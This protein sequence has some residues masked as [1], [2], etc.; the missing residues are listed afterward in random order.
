MLDPVASLAFVAAHT[1]RV[2]LATGI[3]ILP[4]R[5]PLVLAKSLASLDVLSGGRVVFGLGAGYLHQE[6]AALGEP[7]EDRG[8]RTVRHR[9]EIRLPGPN[10]GPSGRAGARPQAQGEARMPC[11]RGVATQGVGEEGPLVPRT[12]SLPRRR[13]SGPSFRSSASKGTVMQ[14]QASRSGACLA[15]KH[16][17]TDCT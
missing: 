8:P 1:E 9:P 17:P 2:K 12:C 4:Q 7:F 3:I 14:R 13:P 5:N 15:S 11:G 10:A 16:P 6:F